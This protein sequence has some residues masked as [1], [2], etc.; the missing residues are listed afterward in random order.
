MPY[1]KHK[2]EKEHHC[3]CTVACE[4]HGYCVLCFKTHARMKEHPFCLHEENGVPRSLVS[5]VLAR[6]EAAGISLDEKIK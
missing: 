6:L 3:P 2:K 5:R 1:T 4:F